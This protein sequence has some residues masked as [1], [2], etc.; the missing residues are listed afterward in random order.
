VKL[1]AA[2]AIALGGCAAPEGSIRSWDLKKPEANAD[3]VVALFEHVCVRHFEHSSRMQT[4]VRNSRLGFKTDFA[5]NAEWGPRWSSAFARIS[6]SDH[7][8]AHDGD[9]CQVDLRRPAAPSAEATIAALRSRRLIEGPGQPSELGATAF[10]RGSERIIV[11]HLGPD[12]RSG[13]SEDDAG[14]M[15]L[16][17]RPAG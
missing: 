3:T 7:G 15:L 16:I 12:P 5:G 4:A 11:R 2:A 10:A 8:H 6:A 13:V 14:L 9:E 1:L 17:K